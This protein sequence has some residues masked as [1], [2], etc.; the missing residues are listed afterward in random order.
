M[1]KLL[2]VLLTFLMIFSLSACNSESASSNTKRD[3]SSRSES[4]T[5]RNGRDS[6]KEDD[7][8]EEPESR[9]N[10][11]RNETEKGTEDDRQTEEPE[12]V[13]LE[14][15]VELAS[16]SVGDR[17]YFGSYEQD[18]D[19]SN[20]T[21]P[22]EWQVLAK[23]NGRILVIS[24]YVL[25]MQPLRA[26]WEGQPSGS[27]TTWDSCFLRHWLNMNFYDSAFS[28]AEKAVIPATL[29]TA[30]RI[31][32]ISRDP[33][34]DTNDKVFILST[35]E[36]RQYFNG[37]E[38]KMLCFPTA[39]VIAK[40]IPTWSIYKKD[41]TFMDGVTDYWLRTLTNDSGYYAFFGVSVNDY[42]VAPSDTKV[43]VRP[44]LWINVS[45]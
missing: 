26:E 1:K 2:V 10:P 30:D 35:F 18:N 31:A 22:I 23:E 34:P 15:A 42:G 8:D 19:S 41:G 36:M 27:P 40:G 5:R 25:D 32:G 16:V 38:D 7:D 14:A 24:E 3:S 13:S 6:D 21:E 28:S 43:G 4:R 20:G 45:P 17:I 33:G 11:F 9:R 44:C 39:S 29:V 12:E 37:D